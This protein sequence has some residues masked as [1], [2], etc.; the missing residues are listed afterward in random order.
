VILL[1]DAQS[2]DKA[3]TSRLYKNPIACITAIWP[4]EVDA[5]VTEIEDALTAG[6][7]VVVALSYELGEVLQG[8]PYRPSATP[9]IRA[10]RFERVEHLSQQQVSSWIEQQISPLDLAP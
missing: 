7:F 8:L 10:Y 3:P 6:Q 2:T 1:D 5:A 9:L 4:E